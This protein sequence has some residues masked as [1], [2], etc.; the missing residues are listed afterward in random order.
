M[1][2]RMRREK[3]SSVTRSRVS[4]QRRWPDALGSGGGDWLSASP[5]EL[6]ASQLTPRPTVSVPALHVSFSSNADSR[7]RLHLQSRNSGVAAALQAG[8]AL[9]RA[10]LVARMDADDIALPE[11][12][13]LQRAYMDAHPDVDVLGTAV[14]L[15]QSGPNGEANAAAASSSASAGASTAAASASSA[16]SSS[17]LRV[18]THPQSP[19]LVSWAL[20]FY[21][22]LASPTVMFRAA[23]VRDAGGFSLGWPSAEDLE[24]WQRMARRGSRMANLPEVLLRLRKHSTN[25]SAATP[26]PAD[27]AAST[28]AIQQPLLRSSALQQLHALMATQVHV[29]LLVQGAVSLEL[30]AGLIRP[31]AATLPSVGHLHSAFMLLQA[32]EAAALR[33]T[34]AAGSTLSK[35]DQTAIKRDCTARMGELVTLA[36]QMDSSPPAAALY[37]SASTAAAQSPLE[38]LQRAAAAAPRPS[39]AQA[40]CF[41]MPSV[42]VSSRAMMGAWMARGADAAALLSKL[43]LSGGK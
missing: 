29:S 25:V 21:C 8:L 43:L 10:P 33:A 42:G 39:N 35:D 20:P 5:A 36:M 15:F 37:A 28:V 3:Y 4:S 6:R 17:T 38:A 27:P 26:V 34:D 32:L 22:P 11:R 13:A 30:V 12:L 31:S 14:E 1:A 2:A 18:I 9:V 7:I 40:H 23:S 41:S 24:L 19:A 16:S